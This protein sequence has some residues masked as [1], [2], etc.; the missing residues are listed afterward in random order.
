VDRS[1]C[2]TAKVIF[3]GLYARCTKLVENSVMTCVDNFA[4]TG[5]CGSKEDA[6]AC[7][8]DRMS[9]ADFMRCQ[10]RSSLCFYTGPVLRIL[11]WLSMGGWVCSLICSMLVAANHMDGG[12]KADP[13]VRRAV[14]KVK[15]RE[16]AEWEKQGLVISKYQRGQIPVEITVEIKLYRIELFCGLAAYMALLS[17]VANVVVMA[18]WAKNI[19]TR[20][21]LVNAGAGCFTSSCPVL[22]YGF[23]FYMGSWV[24]MLLASILNF[25]Q[26]SA[27]AKGIEAETHKPVDYTH[28]EN[29]ENAM[30]R[31]VNMEDAAKHLAACDID[32]INAQHDEAD[33]HVQMMT[34]ENM[35]LQERKA[36]ED[37]DLANLVSNHAAQEEREMM[38]VMAMSLDHAK[39]NGDVDEEEHAH[40]HEALHLRKKMQK[41]VDEDKPVPKRLQTQHEEME[42][43]AAQ[44]EYMT[45]GSMAKMSAAPSEVKIVGLDSELLQNDGVGAE[46][47]RHRGSHLI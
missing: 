2:P 25:Y 19:H 26:P 17:C 37:E 20:L 4:P 18:L 23:F 8:T 9:E 28:H 47:V 44:G 34:S 43:R 42:H 46:T 13:L 7:D 21:V 29:H 16:L 1:Q 32:S 31:A 5:P 38:E 41:Y 36:Q 35:M 27:L 11:T 40:Q 10:A 45:K 22:S 3:N 12:C 30:V 33:L 14:R 24:F 15:L 6:E 39:Q